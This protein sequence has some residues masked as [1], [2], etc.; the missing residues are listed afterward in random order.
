MVQWLRIFSAVQG[1]QIQSLM[2]EHKIPHAVE[3]FSPYPATAEPEPVASMESLYAS[4][5]DPAYCN[6]DLT[7]PNR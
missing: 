1:M 5:K 4:I 7:P 6:K 2:W 3:K